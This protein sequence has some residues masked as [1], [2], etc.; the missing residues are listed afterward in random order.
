MNRN[1]ILLFAIA[2][3]H[4][5]GMTSCQQSD[6]NEEATLFAQRFC[7]FV[8]QHQLDSI[9]SY[10]PDA[11]L[12]DSFALR[13]VADSI[14]VKTNEQADTFHI[15]I[16]DNA[17]FVAIKTAGDGF[18][19]MQSH[20]MAAF[21]DSEMKFAKATGQ[22]KSELTDVEL[23]KRMRDK[24]FKDALIHR[25]KKEF[26]SMVYA[27]KTF[28]EIRF[29]MFSADEGESAAIVD[30]ET[31]KTIDGEDYELRIYIDG[32]HGTGFTTLNGKDLMPNGSAS[33]NF[34]YSGNSMPTSSRVVFK[35][36]DSQLFEKYYEPTGKEFE[37]YMKNN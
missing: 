15:T 22:Y 8:S 9:R 29:P 11:A 36:T 6:P 10:Y 32:Q 2:I 21:S 27:R 5:L 3:A 18:K 35:L 23:S 37:E 7:S 33:F 26:S 24:D 25:F 30:N 12:C 31:S 20:G 16:N 4:L 34:T 1:Q 17:S 28:N 13:Y 19:V 14:I